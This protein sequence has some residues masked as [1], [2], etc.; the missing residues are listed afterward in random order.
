[1]HPSVLHTTGSEKQ[2]RGQIVNPVEID[3][4]V[5]TAIL[6]AVQIRATCVALSTVAD[7]FPGGPAQRE[8]SGFGQISAAAEPDRHAS[9]TRIKRI[10]S[11]TLAVGSAQ[12]P[13]PTAARVEDDARRLEKLCT[14]CQVSQY[15]SQAIKLR[16]SVRLFFR[17]L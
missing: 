17:I 16:L 3:R 8:S 4:G 9:R 2:F 13:T 10:L 15:C 1:M 14:Y 6:R 7:R 12:M 5:I 11:P